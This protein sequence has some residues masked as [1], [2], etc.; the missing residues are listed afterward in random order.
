M[1]ERAFLN[2]KDVTTDWMESV[3]DSDVTRDRN[4]MV[5]FINHSV[6]IA[7]WSDNVVEWEVRQVGLSDHYYAA[8]LLKNRLIECEDDVQNVFSVLESL[9][10]DKLGL[11]Q[12]FYFKED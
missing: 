9:G 2:G 7:H 8:L 12:R 3:F 11:I 10:G 1:K 4:T 5:G 6:V